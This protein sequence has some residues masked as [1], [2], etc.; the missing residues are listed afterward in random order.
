[1]RR[2]NSKQA[3]DFAKVGP[4]G[5]ACSNAKPKLAKQK[6]CEP[7]GM[8]TFF[9]RTVD[10]SDCSRNSGE[11][12]SKKPNVVCEVQQGGDGPPSGIQAAQE[13]RIPVQPG[14]GNRIGSK[15]NAAERTLADIAVTLILRVCGAPRG[16]PPMI[17]ANL[18]DLSPTSWRPILGWLL[19]WGETKQ[20][21]LLNLSETVKLPGY[22]TGI[23]LGLG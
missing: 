14:P 11:P 8:P 3:R 9:K 19:V 1:M 5:A 7:K 18:R 10:Q 6:S 15:R 22:P 20:L 23:G 13:P 17:T 16:K 21:G 4:L 2:T 12:A